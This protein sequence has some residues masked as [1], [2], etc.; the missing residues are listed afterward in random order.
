MTRLAHLV[1]SGVIGAGCVT[2][3]LLFHRLT[4]YPLAVATLL[5]ITAAVIYTVMRVVGTRSAAARAQEP[6]TLIALHVVTFTIGLH[7]LVI[8]TLAG[9]GWARALGPR[10][11]VVLLGVAIAAAG[12]VLPLL[13]PNLAVGIRSARSL[14][15]V[16][17]WSRL[18]RRAG[19]GAVALG[20]VIC[21]AGLFLPGHSIGPVIG[22]A[23]MVLG[24][25]TAMS[26]WRHTHD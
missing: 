15:D 24:A 1:V 21:T 20:V 2:S 6:I 17:L 16:R 13:R 11:P 12:N 25:P 14:D 7:V 4:V 22:V 26:Y 23:T 3:L 19:H 5:P 18:H 9:V 8:C 10:A